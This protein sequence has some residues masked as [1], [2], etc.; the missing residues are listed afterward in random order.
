MNI[1]AKNERSEERA[2]CGNSQNE[3]IFQKYMNESLNQCITTY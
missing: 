1:R 2:H 3:S